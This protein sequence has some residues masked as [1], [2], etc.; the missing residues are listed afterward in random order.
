[1]GEN[2]EIRNKFWAV[3]MQSG[4]KLLSN[5]DPEQLCLKE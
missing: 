2:I 5:P 4:A 3:C 1:M